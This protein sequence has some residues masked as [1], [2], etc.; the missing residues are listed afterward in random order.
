MHTL[1]AHPTNT[2][3]GV[4]LAL[5]DYTTSQ[6]GVHDLI[7]TI[8]NTLDREFDTTASIINLVIDFLEDEEKKTDLLGMWNTF[9]IEC[10]R[11]FPDLIILPPGT[12]T[13]YAGITN[14][15]ML[16]ATSAHRAVWDRVAQHCKVE[17][18]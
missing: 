1:S 17:S 9:K 6:S 7:S 12:S 2:V 15:R 16:I 13:D 8:W 5:H 14:P 18:Y 11:E 3:V 10:R 4:K